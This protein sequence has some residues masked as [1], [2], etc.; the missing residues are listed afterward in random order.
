MVTGVR[1]GDPLGSLFFCL[2]LHL[3]FD[4]VSTSYPAVEVGAYI[5]DIATVGPSGVNKAAT[6]MLQD[7]LRNECNMEISASKSC[8]YVSKLPA[9]EV[10]APEVVVYHDISDTLQFPASD[11]MKCLGVPIGS[12]DKVRAAIVKKVEKAAQ[13]LEWIPKLPPDVAYALLRYCIEARLV[14]LAR[15]LPPQVVGQ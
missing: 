11:C 12:I 13:P 5:D 6:A 1:Q 15:S 2:G 10:G 4:R 14:F 7:S 3:V 9:A 8:S